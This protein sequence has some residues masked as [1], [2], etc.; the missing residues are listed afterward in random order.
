[1]ERL[2][3]LVARLRRE[4]PWDRKQTI[5]S[6]QRNLLEEAY[7]LVA[8]I[9]KRDYRKIAEE[10]GDYIFVGLFVARILEDTGHAR[11]DEIIEGISEKLIRRH[12]HVFKGLKVR[13]AEEV[14]HNWQQIKVREQTGKGGTVSVLQ[15]IPKALPALQRATSVQLRAKRVGFDW[16]NPNDV[17]DKVIEEVAEIRN[18]LKHTPARRRNQRRIREEFGDLLFAL[19]NMAR[20]LGIDSE[21]ALQRA[22]DKFIRRFELME[23]IVRRQG[24]NLEHCSLEELD[25]V[26][27]SLKLRRG[28]GKTAL[29]PGY[30]ACV[31]GRRQPGKQQ[32]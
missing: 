15:G 5:T 29:M 9:R 10:L 30:S 18:E 32:E 20:H 3:R 25:A 24:K 16:Q 12:P 2:V 17:L 31:V 1:M 26:W 4:C 13:D 21:D 11:L 8:A 27:D 23:S 28:K 6:V 19:T 7:E 22:T 14:L